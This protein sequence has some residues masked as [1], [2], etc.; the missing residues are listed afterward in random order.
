MNWI[1]LIL[2]LVPSIVKGIQVVHGDT[3]SGATKKQMA[4]DAL[5]TA[6]QASQTVL[7]GNNANLAQAAG[8]IAGVAIDQTVAI[9]QAD[10]SYNKWTA[11]A[12]SAEQD[13]PIAQQVL[14]TATGSTPAVAPETVASG[15]N[16][17]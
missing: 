10:G 7:T 6:V 16:K 14:S 3:I 9:A 15:V 12:N 1:Q 13:L 11:I 5:A 17:G 2:G 8:A 4:Q